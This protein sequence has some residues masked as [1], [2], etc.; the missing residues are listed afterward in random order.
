[1]CVVVYVCVCFKFCCTSVSSPI[2]K[3]YSCSFLKGVG[4]R[5]RTIIKKIQTINQL[6]NFLLTTHY[7]IHQRDGYNTQAY[8]RQINVK[9]RPGKKYLPTLYKYWFSWGPGVYL[10]IQWATIKHR[11][12]KDNQATNVSREKRKLHVSFGVYCSIWTQHLQ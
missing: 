9:L 6:K 12:E 1:M 10:E 8:R 11:L 7:N 3:E 4:Q 2:I 5:R